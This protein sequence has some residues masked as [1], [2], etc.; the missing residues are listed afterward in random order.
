MPYLNVK[1][2]TALSPAAAKDI[3]A[4]L[5]RLTAEELKKKRE[6]T[7]IA[8]EQVSGNQWFIGDAAV[9]TANGATFYLEIKVTEGTNTKDEKARYIEKVFTAMQAALGTLNPASYV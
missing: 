7:S 2:S 5:T 3:A 4:I 8:I 9:D 6:L 1:I